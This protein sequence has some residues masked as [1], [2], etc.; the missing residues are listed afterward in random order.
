MEKFRAPESVRASS[1]VYY[2]GK[3]SKFSSVRTFSYLSFF[4]LSLSYLRNRMVSK[5]PLGVYLGWI[6]SLGLSL[7]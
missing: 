4:D 3:L 1:F 5:H 2:V 7:V 6:N